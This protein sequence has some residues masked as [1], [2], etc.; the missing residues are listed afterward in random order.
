M[1]VGLLPKDHMLVSSSQKTQTGE[2]R[3]S[4]FGASSR[5]SESNNGFHNTKTETG[6]IPGKIVGQ[7]HQE[8]STL[9]T[10]TQ[11]LDVAKFGSL[12]LLLSSAGKDSSRSFGLPG[13]R[14]IHQK[15]L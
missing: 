12:R 7:E 9:L 13:N 14:G 8:P 5:I 1:S 10:G 11:N 15:P 3:V 4:R 6:Q 2:Q